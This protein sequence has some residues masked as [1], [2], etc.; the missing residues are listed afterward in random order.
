[1]L[2]LTACL[3]GLGLL[4]MPW[5]TADQLVVESTT[6]QL[7]PGYSVYR[8]FTLLNPSE[9]DAVLTLRALGVRDV[10]GGCIRQEIRGGD[11][12]CDQNS[13]E[14]G[15][16]LEISVR[17]QGA[18]APSQALWNGSMRELATGVDMAAS[19]PAETAWRLRVAIAL[20]RA[21]GND[22]MTDRV[23]YD[24]RWTLT[25]DV[26]P[27]TGPTPDEDGHG[28]STSTGAA[29]HGTHSGSTGTGGDHHEVVQV[30]AGGTAAS[31]DGVAGSA[32]TVV[33]TGVLPATGSALTSLS[34]VLGAGLLV[35]GAVVLRRSGRR[36]A[37]RR[38]D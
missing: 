6:G 38:T 36:S 10:E 15:R 2:A 34:V 20:P 21:A 8:E 31:G 18:G 4:A 12:T 32:G 16:W 9:G 7:A 17:A 27:G 35:T 19:I 25:A 22:T 14:L 23:D 30:G 33:D 5:A 24:L 3:L 1:L 29:G 28:E 11:L 37:D 13:G 26:T